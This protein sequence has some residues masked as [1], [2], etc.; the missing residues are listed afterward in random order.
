MKTQ[1]SIALNTTARSAIV[2]TFA[3]A[4]DAAE[5]SASHVHTVCETAQR[6]LK[7]AE[8]SKEDADAI[9]KDVANARG[10]KG[11]SLRARGSE[12]RV[13][14]RAYPQLPETIDAYKAKTKSCTWH[15]A[16]KLARLLNKCEGNVRK[17]VAQALETRNAA[18]VSP[19]G[20]AA[21]ALKAW[22]KE[23][24]SDKKTAIL[25]AAELLGLKLGI[26]LDA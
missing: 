21:G 9:I 6:Y 22:Y 14:L 8:V 16:L 5:N 2:A 19:Q 15:G 24:R 3:K 7:G 10:W 20:R 12:V 23:A 1:P 26:K 13:V 4:Y 11:D 18:P 25:K 17:A